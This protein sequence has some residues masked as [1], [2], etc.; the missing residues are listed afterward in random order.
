MARPAHDLGVRDLA[1]AVDPGQDIPQHPDLIDSERDQHVRMR[2]VATG[3]VVEFAVIRQLPSLASLLGE[4]PQ[5]RSGQRIPG[6]PVYQ[7]PQLARGQVRRA[8]SRPVQVK[9]VDVIGTEQVGF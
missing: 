3:R 7:R 6:E 1:L 9:Q 8:S 4:E 5:L 2:P